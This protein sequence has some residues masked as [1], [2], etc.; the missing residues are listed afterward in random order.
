MCQELENLL[1]NAIKYGAKE[2]GV[3][4]VYYEQSGSDICNQARYLVRGTGPGL[5]IVKNIIEALN[6]EVN[7]DSNLNVN[8]NFNLNKRSEFYISLH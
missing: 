6:G 3:I 1:P 4:K 5:N 2:A 8:L 7:I